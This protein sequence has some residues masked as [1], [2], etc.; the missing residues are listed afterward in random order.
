MPER[1]GEPGV[2]QHVIYIIK[3]NRTYDQVLGDV[4]EGNGDA[5]LVHLW[6]ARHAEPTQA[7]PRFCAAGQHLLLQHFERRRPPMDRQRARDRLHGAR[8]RRLAAQLSQRRHGEDGEDALAYS[9]AGFIW[10]NALAHGKTV[11]DFGEFT[12][13]TKRWKNSGA[14][15]RP[16]FLDS[17][18][19]FTGGTND[20]VYSAASRTSSRCGHSS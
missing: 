15:E 11:R 14:H 5:D 16:R 19:D 4:K 6:R 12:T 8:I 7:R 17:Y 3:E 20:I 9:P 18:R 2:F 10:N 1:A 13:A